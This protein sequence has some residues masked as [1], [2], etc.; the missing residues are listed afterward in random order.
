MERIWLTVFALTA[1][2]LQ[3][4]LVPVVAVGGIAPDL[5]FLLVIFLALQR[6]STLGIWAAFIL[7]LLQDIGGG[8]LI[9]LQAMLLLTLAYLA[10][11][12]RKKFFQ[13]NYLSQIL[14]IVLF[15]F[16]HQF[17]TFFWMN[18]LLDTG[19][20]FNRWLLMA[21]GMSIYHCLVGPLLFRGLGYFIHSQELPRHPNREPGL[22][23]RF[24][25]L[26]RT[27]SR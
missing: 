24:Y 10:V 5:V 3:T 1:V 11:Y 27:G 15:T 8:G 25:R 18:T 14:I 7:G 6:Q 9:G 19:F 4:T 2:V 16:L 26:G 17:L 13:E 20:A 22:R 23:P 12:L 21:L